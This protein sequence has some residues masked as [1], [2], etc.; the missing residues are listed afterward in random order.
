V[1]IYPAEIEN[2]LATHPK[3]ADVGVIGVPNEEWGEEV[4]A[5]VELNEGVE[6]SDDV[7]AE[8]GAYCRENLAG[9]KCPRSIEFRES[10][11]RTDTGKLLK[12]ELREPYWAGHEKKI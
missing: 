5:L 8:L 2:V 11:P 6:P 3:I 9:Y 1:N 7:I 12:R 4:K 10:L